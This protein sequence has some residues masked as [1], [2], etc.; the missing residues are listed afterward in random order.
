MSSAALWAIV[1][2]AFGMVVACA[3]NLSLALD[4]RAA[5]LETTPE[6]KHY[7]KGKLHNLWLAPIWP[8]LLIRFL[9]VVIIWREPF[10]AI[11]IKP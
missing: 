9:S 2:Y 6:L 10:P 4:H 5:G 8:F 3:M 11:H 7:A 1:A